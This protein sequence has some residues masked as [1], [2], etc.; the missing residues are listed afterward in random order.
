MIAF[1]LAAL[2]AATPVQNAPSVASPAA[3]QDAPVRLEDLE[4]TGRSLNST[5]QN[6]VGSVAAPN[7]NR[8][9]ARWRNAVCVGAVNLQPDAGRYLVDKVSATALD[10]GLTPGAPGCTPN[11]LILVTDDAAG[12]SQ[13]LARQHRRA[14]RMGG[15][16]MDRGQTALDEFQT[17]DRPVRWWQV[18][19]PVDGQTGERAT[20]LSGECRGACGADQPKS[21]PGEGGSSFLFAPNIG[22]FAA[23][24]LNTQIVDDIIKTFVVVDVNQLDGVNA[25]QLADYIAMIAFAQIN[26]KADTSGYA[27]ILNVFESPDETAGLTEWDKAY[28]KGLYGTER[29]RKNLAT[30]RLEVVASIERTHQR[31]RDTSAD[32]P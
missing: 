3:D 18:S 26:P 10:I 21:E 13:V 20:R 19:L 15:G 25:D 22:V 8:G 12:L 29:T 16:G 14:L 2:L 23:S 24:R 9:L 6:F 27:S 4:V 32:Q 5:I 1:A 28:L 17:S 31:L 30:G 11:L 7:A